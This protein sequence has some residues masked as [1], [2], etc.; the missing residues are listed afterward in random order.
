M[1][2]FGENKERQVAMSVDFGEI[3]IARYRTHDCPLLDDAKAFVGEAGLRNT[4]QRVL[5]F[6]RTRPS[7]SIAGEELTG[8]LGIF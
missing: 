2:F 8:C 6:H 4:N 3:T 1:T 7:L 5:A